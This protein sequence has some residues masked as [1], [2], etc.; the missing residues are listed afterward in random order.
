MY[1]KC[2]QHVAIEVRDPE[3]SI[4]WY[5]EVLGFKLTE[6]HPAHEHPDIPVELTFMRLGEVHHEIVLVHNPHK[7][8][9]RKP[10]PQEDRAGPVNF[11]HFALECDNREEW[12]AFVARVEAMD[13]EIVRGPVLHSFTQARGDGSWGE[14][15]A[16]YI[17]DPDGH[18]IEIFCDLALIDPDGTH[19]SVYGDRL[20]GTRTEEL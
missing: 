1:P 5:R 2:M 7:E 18:R 4:A 15:E 17:L 14:N 10:L 11:H 16:V 3:R 8:S 6:R 12:I 19:R 20:E 9:T 13:V